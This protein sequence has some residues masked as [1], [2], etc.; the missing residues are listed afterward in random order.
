MAHSQERANDCL[1][2]PAED[3]GL[4][5]N[6]WCLWGICRLE[7]SPPPVP[8]GQP[9]CAQRDEG[10]ISTGL[11]AGDLGPR[12]DACPA[13]TPSHSAPAPSAESAFTKHFWVQIPALPRT[14]DVALGK[15]HDPTMPRLRGVPQPEGLLRGR[16]PQEPPRPPGRGEHSGLGL[17]ETTA[18]P[19]RGTPPAHGL[20]HTHRGRL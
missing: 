15:S 12:S 14:H 5:K 11:S 16:G 7:G 4:F 20:T 8:L 13:Q 2:G 9:P 17:Q 1:K 18:A 10:G 6:F 3:A 19:A